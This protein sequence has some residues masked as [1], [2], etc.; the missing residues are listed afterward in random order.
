MRNLCIIITISSVLLSCRQQ[1]VLVKPGYD[2]TRI[3][4]IIVESVRDYPKAGGS[5]EIVSRSLA[6]NLMELGLDIVERNNVSAVLKE[7]AMSQ[8]GVSAEEQ[9]EV[10]IPPSDAIMLCSIS[11]FRDPRTLFIP[12]EV[13]DRGRTVSVVETAYAKADSANAAAEGKVVTEETTTY[14]GSVR[15]TKEIRHIDASVG[16]TLQMVDPQ[17]GVTVWSS[18]FSYSSLNKSV[19]LNR[20]VAGALRPLKKVLDR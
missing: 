9:K 17:K 6:H 2:F 3:K 13:E 20:C 15:R 11:D 8:S 10:A 16:I 4:T 14:K 1:N 5:G 12:I 19:A 18:S 7:T